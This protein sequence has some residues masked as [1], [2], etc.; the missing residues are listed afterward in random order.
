MGKIKYPQFSEESWANIS[1]HMPRLK[2]RRF[3]H[4]GR[5]P[6]DNNLVLHAVVYAL[7][8]NINWMDLNTKIFNVSG[9]TCWRHLKGWVESDIWPDIVRILMADSQIEGQNINWKR[10]KIRRRRNTQTKN[11]K[12]AR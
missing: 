9:T 5:T 12:G 8:N 4:P 11:Q 10:A 6:T 2:K 3:R 7:K 1:T